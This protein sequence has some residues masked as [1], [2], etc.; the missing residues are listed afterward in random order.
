MLLRNIFGDYGINGR[1]M[2][3]VQP[4][5]TDIIVAFALKRVQVTTLFRYCVAGQPF[6]RRNNNENMHFT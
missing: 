3:T 1:F 5:G 6:Q 2:L 4:L